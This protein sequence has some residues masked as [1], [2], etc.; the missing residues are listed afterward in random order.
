M[1]KHYECEPFPYTRFSDGPSLVFDWDEE[2][3]EISGSGKAYFSQFEPNE[4]LHLPHPIPGITY[5]LSDS[6][7]KSKNDM[8]AMIYY[9]YILP[10]DL[11]KYRPP[12]KMREAPPGC[13][14]YY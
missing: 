4:E 7:F 2:T 10:E 11:K 6:P 14:I 8:A 13:T 9:G 3:G 12:C 5:V 1:K